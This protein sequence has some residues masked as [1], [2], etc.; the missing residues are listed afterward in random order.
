VWT[1][2]YA[3][4][5]PVSNGPLISRSDGGQCKPKSCRGTIASPSPCNEVYNGSSLLTDHNSYLRNQDQFLPALLNALTT[6]AYH[7]NCG[8]TADWQLVDDDHLDEAK[9][10][11]RRLVRGLVTARVL[12][13]GVVVLA[14]LRSPVRVF[15]GPMNQ[16]THLA[17]PHMHMSHGL[18][19]LVAVVL[20]TAASYLVVAVIPR[21]IIG[22]RNVQRFF[23]AAEPYGDEPVTGEPAGDATQD[24]LNNLP[25]ESAG[26]R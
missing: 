19:R 3:S 24:K 13:A 17:G 14:W 10:R 26:V 20:I 15:Q 4:A 23:Q 7:D 2:F 16:L 1:D 21:Q 9:Q 11:R 5:D 22:Y 25:P 6:A 18:V 8:S 12:M